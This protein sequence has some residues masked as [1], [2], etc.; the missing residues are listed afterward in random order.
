VT[1]PGGDGR[2]AAL[3]ITGALGA[4]AAELPLPLSAW[5]VNVYSVPPFRPNTVAL[6]AGGVPVIVVGVCAVAPM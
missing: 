5:T 6:V 2:L 3:G 1:F 4:D